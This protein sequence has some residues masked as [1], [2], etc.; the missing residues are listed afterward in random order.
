MG[1]SLWLWSSSAFRSFRELLPELSWV[2][3]VNGCSW[4]NILPVGFG[5]IN[6][7]FLCIIPFSRTQS[8]KGTPAH[9]CLCLIETLGPPFTLSVGPEKALLLWG[10]WIL[11]PVPSDSPHSLYLN[12]SRPLSSFCCGWIINDIGGHGEFFPLTA[13]EEREFVRH[14]TQV[15]FA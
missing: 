3:R 11:G 1:T 12:T 7:I 13:E 4:I 15:Y 2:R 8:S 6:G 5:G 10:V 9:C 14:H